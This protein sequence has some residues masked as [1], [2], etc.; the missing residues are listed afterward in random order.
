ML[1]LQIQSTHGAYPSSSEYGSALVV[2]QDLY[3]PR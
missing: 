2:N 3:R 1:A